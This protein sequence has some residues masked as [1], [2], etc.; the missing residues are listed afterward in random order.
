MIHVDEERFLCQFNH[1]LD[2][3]RILRDK[4]WLYE[5]YNLV[6]E[7]IAPGEVP[8]VVPLNHLELWVQVLNLPFNT[9]RPGVGEGI[10]N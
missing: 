6:L 2:A 9:I 1:R 10:G 4:L 8:T 7:R 3:E 5:G